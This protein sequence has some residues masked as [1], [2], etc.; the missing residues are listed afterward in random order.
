MN[1]SLSKFQMEDLDKCLI[2]IKDEDLYDSD[3]V[4]LLCGHQYHLQCL[5]DWLC[6]NQTCPLCRD[7]VDYKAPVV[8]QVQ[9]S[10]NGDRRNDDRYLY[11]MDFLN[12]LCASLLFVVYIILLFRMI[13]LWLLEPTCLKCIYTTNVKGFE[14]LIWNTLILF[15]HGCYDFVNVNNLEDLINFQFYE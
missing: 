11:L 8:I 7:E 14:L 3:Y 2:C 10:V 5:S 13:Y 12:R 6:M 9:E 4:T 15:I 1:K